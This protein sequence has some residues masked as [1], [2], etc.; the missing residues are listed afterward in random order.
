MTEFFAHFTPVV[1]VLIALGTSVLACTVI[2]SAVAWRGKRSGRLG[3]ASSV[4]SA[5]EY[6]DDAIDLRTAQAFSEFR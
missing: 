5:P 4:R 3:D 6:A 1:V 2:T